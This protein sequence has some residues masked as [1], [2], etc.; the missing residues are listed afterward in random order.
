MGI[1]KALAKA[2]G[3]SYEGYDVVETDLD[4]AATVGSVDMH[5]HMLR[6]ALAGFGATVSVTRVEKGVCT[7]KY[8]GP[9]PLGVGLA[10]AVKENFKDINEVIIEEE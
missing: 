2:F 3:S 8:D 7:L 1:A 4:P 9:P 6:G 5:L 10:K